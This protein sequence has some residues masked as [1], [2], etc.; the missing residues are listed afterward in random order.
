[1]QFAKENKT[2]ERGPKVETMQ[3]ANGEGTQINN[4]ARMQNITI[5]ESKK[6]NKISCIR[7]VLQKIQQNNIIA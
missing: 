4:N 3:S 6:Q 5:H 1:M 2:R 7:A